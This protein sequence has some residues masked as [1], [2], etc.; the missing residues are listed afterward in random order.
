MNETFVGLI[1]NDPNSIINHPEFQPDPAYMSGKRFS[2]ADLIRIATT[3]T[4]Q[5][6][7]TCPP[8]DPKAKAG[9]DTCATLTFPNP[10]TQAI[11]RW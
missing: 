10:V 4:A 8:V 7:V 1:A 9:K 6:P 11:Y 2:F 3:R 5:P